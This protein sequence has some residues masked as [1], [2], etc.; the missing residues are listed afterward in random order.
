MSEQILYYN[1]KTNTKN[2]KLVGLV[3]W[4]LTPHSAIFLLYCGCQFYCCR[5][6]EGPEKTT[7]LSQVTDKLYQIILKL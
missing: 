4:C 3:L 6:P 1:N 5:K 2:K 7:D